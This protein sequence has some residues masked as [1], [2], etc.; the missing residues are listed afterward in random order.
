MTDIFIDAARLAESSE[1]VRKRALNIQNGLKP[2]LEDETRKVADL[3]PTF[4]AHGFVAFGTALIYTAAT[5][6]FYLPSG[7]QAQMSGTAWGLGLTGQ[8]NYGV[9][10]FWVEESQLNGEMSFTVSGASVL[11]GAARVTWWKGI[12]LVGWYEAFGIGGVG[13]AIT[14]GS[15]TWTQS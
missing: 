14:F 4:L 11:V 2:I 9:A 12:Q 7:K 8:G 10:S 3:A 13:L 5:G 6:T 15:C 1:A